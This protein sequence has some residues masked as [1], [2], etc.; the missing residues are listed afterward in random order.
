MRLIQQSLVDD[1]RWP[2][3][4]LAS[5]RQT[6]IYRQNGCR[7]QRCSRTEYMLRCKYRLYRRIPEQFYQNAVVPDRYSQIFNMQPT[8]LCEVTAATSVP[9]AACSRIWIQTCDA[10]RIKNELTGKKNGRNLPTLNLP[11]MKTRRCRDA[12]QTQCNEISEANARRM[13]SNATTNSRDLLSRL[14]DTHL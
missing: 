6:I 10:Q 7:F 14:Y 2:P 11:L 4:S 1:P 8:R 12:L 13:V 5:L 3:I 9:Y